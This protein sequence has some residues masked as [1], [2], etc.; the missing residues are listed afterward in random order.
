VD[1]LLNGVVFIDGLFFALTGA[2]LFVLRQKR[3]RAEQPP[4]SV[5]PRVPGYPV[6]PLVFVL[7]ELGAVADGGQLDR[8]WVAGF[9][10]YYGRNVLGIHHA[11][12]D[13]P[14]FARP[15]ARWM[16]AHGFTDVEVYEAAKASARGAT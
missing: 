5:L 9:V 1:R 16:E 14:A 7:G 8:S 10:H 13:A 4:A 6:V 15:L 11:R 2:A 12:G 3:A